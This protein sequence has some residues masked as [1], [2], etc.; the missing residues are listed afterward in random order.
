LA[1]N[2]PDLT[3][4]R[5]RADVFMKSVSFKPGANPSIGAPQECGFAEECRRASLAESTAD[6]AG[7][8]TDHGILLLH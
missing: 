5:A 8:G 1:D 3:V 2:S 7:H 4:D 6:R